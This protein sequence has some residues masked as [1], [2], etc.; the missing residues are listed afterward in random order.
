M[1]HDLVRLE[2]LEQEVKYYRTLIQPQDSGHIYTAISFIEDRIRI[3]KGG[4]KEW[5]FDQSNSSV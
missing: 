1:I 5:P 2:V 4:K 3:L